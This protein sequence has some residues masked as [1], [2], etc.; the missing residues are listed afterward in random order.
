LKF[1]KREGGEGGRGGEDAARREEEE[2]MKEEEE[3][4]R[5][6]QGFGKF[7]ALSLNDQFWLASRPAAWS[8][9]TSYTHTHRQTEREREGGG[10]VYIQRGVRV[11]GGEREKGRDGGRGRE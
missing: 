1:S 2:A 3:V 10:R 6:E 11:G 4:L 7:G 8:H 5:E 9:T